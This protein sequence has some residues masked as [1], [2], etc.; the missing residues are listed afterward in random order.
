MVAVSANDEWSPD[1]PAGTEAFEPGD[2]A[3]DDTSGRRTDGVEDMEQ[4]PSLDPTLLADERERQEAGTALDDPEAMAVLDGGI[5]DP[6]G[7]GPRAGDEAATRPAGT[8]MPRWPRTTT[9]TP[10]PSAETSP[11]KGRSMD[12][13]H[14]ATVEKIFGHPV[15]HNIQWHDVMSLLE[16]VGTIKSEHDGR[17][18]V[19]LGSETQTF[20][21]PRH[22]DIDEQQVVDLRRMLSS[23]GI[24]PGSAPSSP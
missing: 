10:I 23:A 20:E 9:T 3:L 8:S 2:E 7:S 22:A 21:A 14:R 24:A 13:H 11:T 1:E 5:D 17:F 4:D 16:A 15:S 12:S 6:D 19:T 18:K